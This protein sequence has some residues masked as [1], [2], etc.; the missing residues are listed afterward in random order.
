MTFDNIH[1][2]FGQTHKLEKFKCNIKFHVQIS[3]ELQYI[4]LYHVPHAQKHIGIL[5]L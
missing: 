5:K 2:F 1:A 4:N 3:S